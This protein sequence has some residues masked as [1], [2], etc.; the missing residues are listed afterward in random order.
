[1][2]DDTIDIE[3]LRGLFRKANEQCNEA[4]CKIGDFYKSEATWG[5]VICLG[6]MKEGDDFGKP[7]VMPKD[8]KIPLTE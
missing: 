1:M 7:M 2:S 8:F 6:C 5:N 3:K 4:N